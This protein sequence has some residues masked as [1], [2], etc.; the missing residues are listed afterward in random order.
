[1]ACSTRP[2]LRPLQV[3]S[4]ASEALGLQ[5]FWL[6]EPLAQASPLLGWPFWPYVFILGGVIGLGWLSLSATC[7][8]EALLGPTA[9]D[10]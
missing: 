8:D 7:R 10:E 6:A 5:M 9:A 2:Q 3:S 4:L 1:M